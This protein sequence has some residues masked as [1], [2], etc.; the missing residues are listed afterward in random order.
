[1]LV[2]YT[3]I[4]TTYFNS[5]LI[6][7]KSLTHIQLF[8][9]TNILNTYLID[10]LEFANPTIKYFIVQKNRNSQKEMF[11]IVRIRGGMYTARGETCRFLIWQLKRKEKQ[12]F[13]QAEF[14]T[15][16]LFALL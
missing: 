16:L 15:N 6:T 4:V 13:R 5:L 11:L 8:A 7:N 14:L 1:M 3:S 10:L 12:L 9:A 2:V